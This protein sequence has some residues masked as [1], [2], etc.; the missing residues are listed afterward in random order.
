MPTADRKLRPRR[1]APPGTRPTMSWVELVIAMN[2]ARSD[3][4]AWKALRPDAIRSIQCRDS[5]N[6]ASDAAQAFDAMRRFTPGL[7]PESIDHD[8]E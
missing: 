3:D 1:R 8:D 7:P 4:Q 5:R 2:R 6:D